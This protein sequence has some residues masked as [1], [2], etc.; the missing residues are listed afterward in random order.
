MTTL[1]FIGLGAM[2]LPMALNLR[3]AGH[4]LM[5][6]ARN[7]VRALALVEEGAILTDSPLDLAPRVDALFINVSDDAAVEAVLFGSQGAA[8][9]LR[10]GSMVV[11]MGTTSPN[12]TRGFA[13]RLA[14][15]GVEWLDAPVSGGESGAQAATLSIMVGGNAAAFTRVL[16]LFQILGKNVV[17]VGATGAGQV[18]KACNQIV[19]SATLLG[20]AEALTFARKQGVDPGKVREALLGGFAYSRILEVH[21]QRMLDRQFTPGFRA[22]LHQKDLGIVLAEA[23]ERNLAMPCATLAAQLLDALVAGGE[24]ELDSAALVKIVEGLAGLAL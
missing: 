4:D 8:S 21:G 19:V 14:Q 15:T 16:P 7:P 17:H 6:F 24:G 10:S 13:S 11:D 1:G 20:V 23:R 18:A 22:R 12:A 5:V 9:G 2:G 3:R